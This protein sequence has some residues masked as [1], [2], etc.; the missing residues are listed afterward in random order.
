MVLSMAACGTPPAS[1]SST[2]DPGSGS[3][4]GSTAA[5]NPAASGTIYGLD[6]QNTMVLG[7][8]SDIKGLDPMLSSTRTEASVLDRKSVV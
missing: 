6:R 3:V 7:M 1:S 5:P 8:A 2:G 4:P